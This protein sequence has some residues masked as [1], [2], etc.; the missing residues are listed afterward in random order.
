MRSRHHSATEA[1]AATNRSSLYSFERRR[2]LTGSAGLCGL[3]AMRALLSQE[4]VLGAEPG[5]LPGAPA[6]SGLPAPHFPPRAKNC[7]FLFL[8]GGTSQ[9]ELFDPKPKL[10]T[11]A[12]SRVPMSLLRSVSPVLQKKWRNRPIMASRFGYR[13]YGKCGTEM[14]EL[15][16]RIGACADDIALVRSMYHHTVDHAQGE[17]FLATGR[18]QPGRPSG[19]AWLSYGLGSP[20]RDLPSY[21]VLLNGRG[22]LSRELVWGNGALP[23]QHRGVLLR[24]QGEP[25]LNLE[26]PAGLPVAVK[27]R[28]LDA[29]IG[30]NRRQFEKTLD[31]EIEARIASYELAFRMQTAAPELVDL[32]R[33]PR[34]LRESY[35]VER[36]GQAGVF[37]RNC[38]L[39]RRMVERGVRFVTLFQAKWDHHKELDAGLS[40]QCR[41]VD[42][43]IGAL[44]ED[45]KARGMLDSTLVVWATE[46]GRTPITD[47]ADSPGPK[48]GRG[49]HPFAFSMWMAGGGVRGGQV[50]GS[51]DELSWHAAEDKVHV[52]DFNATLLH[53]FG[54]DHSRLTYRSGG[55]DVR[56]TNQEGEVVE[57]LLV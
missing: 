29:I 32:S 11:L 38:L 14:S 45:L 20:A 44:L 30:L 19:G 31:P 3:A 23:S 50:I 39:A 28:R 6:G 18:D 57:R 4:G 36:S 17:L 27:Q 7:I 16:P 22:P 25:I 26:D 55:A 24:S 2:F 53:L 15:L 9:I 33:E 56:L 40:S 51:T 10:E 12:G 48:A 8:A 47:G 34:R 41:E 42:Q 37:S 52:H 1:D 35:G 13:R 46:F 43:P 5:A 21:V 54:L 49:H